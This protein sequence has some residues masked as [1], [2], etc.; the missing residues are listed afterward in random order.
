MYPQEQ[1]RLTTV[2]PLT[3]LPLQV[4]ACL[5]D[6]EVML[7]LGPGEHGSTF[8]GNPLA[9]RVAVAALQVMEDERLAERADRLGTILR[10]EL[11]KLPEDRVTSVRGKGLLNAVVVSDSEWAGEGRAGAERTGEGTW[12][13]AEGTGR[14]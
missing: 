5:A 6:D 9:C 7:C 3:P 8:G 1:L 4:S 2:T 12:A 14:G 10:A 11:S 13:K